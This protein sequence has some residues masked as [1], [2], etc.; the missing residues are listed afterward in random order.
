MK[1]RIKKEK[2]KKERG[3]RWGGGKKDE[4]ERKV[5]RSSIR[6]RM[7]TYGNE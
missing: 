6:T 2:G 1:R 4:R 3:E 7:Q 5:E